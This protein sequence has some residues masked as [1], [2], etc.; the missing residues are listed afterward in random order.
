MRHDIQEEIFTKAKFVGKILAQD[1][2]CMFIIFQLATGLQERTYRPLSTFA[3]L[4]VNLMGI[5]WIFPSFGN[6]QLKNYHR[7]YFILTNNRET[8]HSID[9][10]DFN[11]EERIDMVMGTEEEAEK[12]D[13]MIEGEDY[14]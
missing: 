1:A 14:L 9:R 11:V 8:Y 2:V 4:F 13:S 10:I 6:K 12:E 5:F 7:L 3:F